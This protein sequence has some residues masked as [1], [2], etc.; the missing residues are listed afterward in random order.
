MHRCLQ[1]AKLGLANAAPNPSVGAVLVNQN[2]IVAEGYTSPYGGA[3]AEVN[4]LNQISNSTILNEAT[5]YVSL[6]PCSHFGKTPPCSNLIIDKGIKKV[7]IACRDDNPLV[8][9][10]GI[11]KLEK[12][13]ITVIEN[14]LEEEAKALN[15][16]FFTFHTKKRPYI[17]LK[18]AQTPNGFFAPNNNNQFW[19]TTKKTKALVHSWRSQEMA[20]LVGENTIAT[21]NP[22]LNTRLVAGKNP[23]R[24]IINTTKRLSEQA[25]VF[26]DGYA[27]ILFSNIKYNFTN[28]NV[29]IVP[30]IEN[31]TVV[32]QVLHYLYQNN[33]NSLIVE[34]GA[35][36]LQQF[37]AENLWDEARVLQ[38]EKELHKGIKAPELEGIITEK[39]NLNAD[40]ITIITNQNA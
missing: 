40:F 19:I 12:A 8:A 21:D 20:I 39:I 9:G 35:Y 24:V 28:T 33:I 15:K 18:W 37:I 34:G 31:T 22:R 3:H 36:T 2:K 30:I 4:C 16:R 10:S 27:T 26:T 32:Q 6:E 5:L 17:I 23:L 1:L 29:V 25:K 38:G 13:G 14:V 11:E 7:V